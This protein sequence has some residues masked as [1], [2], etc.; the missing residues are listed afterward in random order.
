MWQN[1][2]WHEQLLTFG[3]LSNDMSLHPISAKYVEGTRY[4]DVVGDFCYF[5]GAQPDAQ[6]KDFVHVALSTRFNNILPWHA[7]D[8]A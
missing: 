6:K 3:L 5:V 8:L 7:L 2:T 1:I 4:L